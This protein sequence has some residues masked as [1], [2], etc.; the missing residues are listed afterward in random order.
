MFRELVGSCPT[1]CV[2]SG[3]VAGSAVV[4][5]VVIAATL[6]ATRGTDSHSHGWNDMRHAIPPLIQVRYLTPTPTPASGA[7]MSPLGG[8]YDDM[9][10]HVATL[11]ATLD[12]VAHN[13]E[14]LPSF[15]IADVMR[16]VEAEAAAA[17]V[18]ADAD[19]SLGAARLSDLIQLA[20]TAKNGV[21]TPDLVDESVT[22]RPGNPSP[23]YPESLLAAGVEAVVSVRFV[24]DS[25]GKVDEPT[26]EFGTHVQQLFM[27]AIRASLRRARFFPARFAGTVVPQLV[28]QEFRFELR[29]RP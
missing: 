3:P 6:V 17:T 14:I 16:A 5:A 18:A 24:V 10:A 11:Q 9:S 23:R 12:A 13:L 4:H 29:Q 1:R 19:F 7:R 20:P 21:Y 25:T 15:D 26:I 8:R 2:R 27:D 28:Q 22:L